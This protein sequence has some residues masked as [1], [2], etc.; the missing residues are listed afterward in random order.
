MEKTPHTSKQTRPNSNSAACS[1]S[2]KRTARNETAPFG[3]GF[4]ALDRQGTESCNLLPLT[5]CGT[6]ADHPCVIGHR[7]SVTHVSAT[8]LRA[9]V[10]CIK[11][12]TLSFFQREKQTRNSVNKQKKF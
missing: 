1:S 12:N 2:R 8:L 6:H 7:L 3:A 5:A 9:A 11:V 10:I 4:N